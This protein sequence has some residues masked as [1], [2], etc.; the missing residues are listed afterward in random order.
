LQGYKRT[1]NSLRGC[2]LVKQKGGIPIIDRQEAYEKLRKRVLFYPLATQKFNCPLCSVHLLL[3]RQNALQC[4]AC[5]ITFEVRTVW[6]EL[7]IAD[8]YKQLVLC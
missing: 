7:P 8:P 5:A 6:P 1:H 2:F 3:E 4:P